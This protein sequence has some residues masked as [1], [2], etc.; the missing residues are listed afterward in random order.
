MPRL[1]RK[2]P[3][4]QFCVFGDIFSLGLGTFFQNTGDS[5]SSRVY[6]TFLYLTNV[7]QV[8]NSQIILQNN[9]LLLPPIHNR[10]LWINTNKNLNSM[11][12]VL[13]YFRLPPLKGTFLWISSLN[14]F[15]IKFTYTTFILFIFR[16]LFQLWIHFLQRFSTSLWG[17]NPLQVVWFL[18][19]QSQN[20]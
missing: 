18:H 11:L 20:E 8:L 4:S 3:R 13:F 12:C 7:E 2:S 5:N 9:N 1:D 10:T 17:G 19:F 6:N 15:L 16:P 14:I